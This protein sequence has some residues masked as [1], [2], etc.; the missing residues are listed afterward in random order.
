MNCPK[1]NRTM[2]VVMHFENGRQYQYSKCA[3]CCDRTK[4]K[5]IHFEDVLKDGCFENNPQ[6]KQNN[7]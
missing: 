2:K 7:K 5:R 3:Y 4:N 6:T 1:C